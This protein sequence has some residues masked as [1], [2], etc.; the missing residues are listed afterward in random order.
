[1]ETFPTPL[2]LG[3]PRPPAAPRLAAA[4]VV[5]LVALGACRDAPTD[6]MVG[7]VAEEAGGALAMGMRLPDPSLWSP[8]GAEGEA[9]RA[10]EVWRSSW[11]LPL[12]EARRLRTLAYPALVRGLV[13]VVPRE[14]LTQEAADLGEGVRRALHLDVAKLPPHVAAGLLEASTQH[15]AASAALE[16]GNMEALL[17]ALVRGGDALR[18]VGPEAVARDLVSRV[19]EMFGRISPDDPYSEQGLERLRRLIQGGRQAVDEGDWVLAIRRA[20]YANGLLTEIGRG[21]S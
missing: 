10:L 6:P 15:A 7:L 5:L 18:E 19:E 3:V 13:D 9:G 17:D 1:M 14:V 11:Q 4:C 12:P 2:T 20:Y 16:Q 8:S 21:P